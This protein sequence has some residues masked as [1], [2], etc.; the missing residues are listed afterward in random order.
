MVLL[1]MNPFVLAFINPEE[2]Y[3]P[4]SA[5]ELGQA[6]IGNGIFLG[7]L[8]IAILALII[9]FVLESRRRDGVKKSVKKVGGVKVGK[10][11]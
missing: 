9:V 3:K 2:N 7:F 10:K 1:L 6:K 11:K 8:I 4:D 5:T